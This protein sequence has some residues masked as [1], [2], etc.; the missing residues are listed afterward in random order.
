MFDM[1]LGLVHYEIFLHRNVTT[2]F[3][4]TL[5]V[6]HILRNILTTFVIQGIF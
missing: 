6:F 1:Y 4:D 3:V 5:Y 2:H